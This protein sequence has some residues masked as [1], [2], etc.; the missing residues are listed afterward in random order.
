MQWTRRLRVCLHLAVTGSA[1]LT[2][3]VKPPCM[4][5]AFLTILCLR[6]ICSACTTP[7][8]TI[9]YIP[10]DLEDAHRQLTKMLPAKDIEHIR[11]MRSQDEMVEYHMTV[12]LGFTEEDR[13]SLDE[14]KQTWKTIGTKI[15]DFTTK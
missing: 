4:F 13:N 5:R 10:K 7:R 2:S 9:T 14:L 6:T 15:E 1:P 3:F 11:A 8:R 12:G